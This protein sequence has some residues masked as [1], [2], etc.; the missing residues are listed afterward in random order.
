MPAGSAMREATHHP[1][2]EIELKMADGLIRAYI[3]A[4]RSL[5]GNGS[6][7]TNSNRNLVIRWD[8]GTLKKLVPTY[9]DTQGNN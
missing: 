4:F 3:Y 7:W 2:N 9:A 1:P 8:M 5:Y 6:N